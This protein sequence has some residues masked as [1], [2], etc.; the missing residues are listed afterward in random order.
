MLGR[1]TISVA[2]KYLYRQKVV[3]GKK[4]LVHRLVMEQHLGRQLKE[5]EVVHHKNG[6]VLDNQIENLELMSWEEHDKVHKKILS[7]L[8]EKVILACPVCGAQVQMRLRFYEWR[9]AHGQKAFYCSQKCQVTIP[10]KGQKRYKGGLD[11]VIRR[12]I[13]KGLS[14]YQIA[15]KYSLNKKTVYNHIKSINSG[16][17]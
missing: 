17:V 2:Y 1:Y 10:N 9:K 5:D 8:A 14:G 12:G 7:E 16:V 11:S 15:K 3:N 13:H 4:T 6:N